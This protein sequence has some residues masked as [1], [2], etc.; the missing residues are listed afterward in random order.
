MRFRAAPVALGGLLLLLAAPASSLTAPS[1]RVGSPPA[2]P[3]VTL[4][5]DS[6]AGSISFDI[7]AEA[8]LSQGVDLFL[9]PGEGRRL[10]GDDPPGGDCAAH[11]TS[12]HRER[13]VTS[14]GRP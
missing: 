14:S 4:I 13:S 8:V 12:A 2:L 9:E 10:G 1:A 7:G 3:R 11:C 6:V 5:S